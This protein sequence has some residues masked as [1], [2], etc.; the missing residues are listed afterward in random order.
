MRDEQVEADVIMQIVDELQRPDSIG[1]TWYIASEN[2]HYIKIDNVGDYEIMDGAIIRV[3]PVKTINKAFY[4]YLL[5]SAFGALLHQLQIIPLHASAVEINNKALLFSADSGYGK[6]TLCYAMQKAG[7]RIL[8]DDVCPISISREKVPVVHAAYPQFKLKDDAL[9]RLEVAQHHIKTPVDI[10]KFAVSSDKDFKAGR[11]PL[12]AI[13]FLD[14]AEEQVTLKPVKYLEKILM[15][16]KNIYR[17][18]FVNDQ[19][20]VKYYFNIIGQIGDKTSFYSLKRPRESFLLDE[21]VQH[22]MTEIVEKQ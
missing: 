3:K 9:E 18:F 4:T 7:G 11:V 2:Y 15:F 6:S 17:P 16:K 8:S 13:I 19:D 12:K 1:N 5:G 21:V 14:W 10:D 20:Q 22:I